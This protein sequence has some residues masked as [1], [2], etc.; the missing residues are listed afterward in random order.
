VQVVREGAQQLAEFG[1]K[2]V[3][4]TINGFL[5]TAGIPEE[6]FW[7]LIDRF[8]DAISKLA[9]SVIEIAKKLFAGTRDGVVHF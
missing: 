3:R 1:Q 2:F 9:T 5:R 4:A 7:Q 8:G 6:K